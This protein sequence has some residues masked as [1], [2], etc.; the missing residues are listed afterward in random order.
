V[1]D[2]PFTLT[3]GGPGYATYTITQGILQN[4]LTLGRV[5]QASALSVV[6]MLFVIVVIVAQMVLSRRAEGR[7][8]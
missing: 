1:Y 3:K 8:L 5:G 7:V 4:G 6:F 2:L